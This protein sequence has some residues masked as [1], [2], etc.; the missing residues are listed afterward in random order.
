MMY[1]TELRHIQALQQYEVGERKPMV[2]I[3]TQVADEVA[4]VCS[5]MPHD[6]VALIT[7]YSE[8]SYI[9]F[10]TTKTTLCCRRTTET[11]MK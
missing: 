6:I 2:C 7:V 4:T 1:S 3:L 8:G 10:D 9:P 5:L 11:Y